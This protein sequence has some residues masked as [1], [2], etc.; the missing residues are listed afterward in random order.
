MGDLFR[1][2]VAGWMA[3]PNHF[4]T[5]AQAKG[6]GFRGTFSPFGQQGVGRSDLS[7]QKR[8]S[9][10]LEVQLHVA[11]GPKCGIVHDTFH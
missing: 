2:E 9:Q 5:A 3:Q 6:G 8:G 7:R 4:E 1:C 10:F 11:A